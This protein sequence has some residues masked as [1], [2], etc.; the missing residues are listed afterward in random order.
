MINRFPKLFLLL[1]AVLFIGTVAT[2]KNI[3]ALTADRVSQNI[4]ILLGCELG[5]L[6]CICLCALREAYLLRRKVLVQNEQLRRQALHDHLTQCY[7][8]RALFSLLGEM[9]LSGA[10]DWPLGFLMI[11]VDNFKAINDNFGHAAGDV[12]LQNVAELLLSA[13]GEKGYLARYGGDEFCVL[14]PKTSREQTAA[15]GETLRQAIESHPLNVKTPDSS[16]PVGMNVTLSI[17]A[18]CAENRKTTI[19]QILTAAD[20]AMYQAKQ[21]GKN[22]VEMGEISC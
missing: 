21:A 8:R 7:N 14:L 2:L 12:V 22:R 4:W 10:D 9:E 18:I 1:T 6:L 16:V 15:M 17:G 3:G 5:A 19:D 13:V 11:D 20:A